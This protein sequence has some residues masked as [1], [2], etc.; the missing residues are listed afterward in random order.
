MVLRATAARVHQ[1]NAFVYRRIGLDVARLDRFAGLVQDL[2]A[3]GSYLTREEIRGAVPGELFA[4]EQFTMAYLLMYAELEGVVCSGPRRGNQFTY[5][6]LDQRAGPDTNPMSVEDAQTELVRRYLSARGP[7]TVAD[8]TT[9]SGLTVAQAR[10]AIAALDAEVTTIEADGQA[11]LMLGE[12]DVP[13]YRPTAFLMP[14]Y[15][16]YGMGYKDRSA[17]GSPEQPFPVPPW[18]RVMIV[19]GVIAGGWKRTLAP[20]SVMIKLDML[21]IPAEDPRVVAAA[22]TYASFLGRELVLE[23]VVP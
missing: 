14:D 20:N 19:D 5:A 8:L 12:L 23:R 2:L 22:E 17:I 21:G 9:W 18:N 15:D 11:Y 1:A 10:Q 13:A 4:G 6:L 3:D 16:E 7:A